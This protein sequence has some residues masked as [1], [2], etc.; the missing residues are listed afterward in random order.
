MLKVVVIGLGYVGLPL[1]IESAKSGYSTIGLD[2]DLNRINNLN[3]GI[4]YL[5]DITNISLKEQISSG[6]FRASQD[7][8]EIKQA[9]VVVIC[10]PTPLLICRVNTLR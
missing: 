9:D 3:L 2:I 1:A 4:S 5:E 7:F 6:K 10:V 8:S